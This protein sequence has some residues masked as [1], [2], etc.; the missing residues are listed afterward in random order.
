M[1][2]TRIIHLYRRFRPEF[3]GDG[4]Y[5]EHLI[6]LMAELGTTHI[7]LAFDTPK[8][9]SIPN[10]NF[11]IHYLTS[12]AGE[13][14]RFA[15]IS[16]LW[17][18]RN[19]FDVLHIHSHV[20]RTFLSYW[21]ARAVGL[22]VIYSSTL[23]DSADELL[24]GYRPSFRPLVRL[25]F[26]GIEFF[27]GNSPRLYSGKSRW[28][29]SRRA[30]VI[31]QGT[32]YPTLISTEDRDELRR[33]FGVESGDIVL[34]YVGSICARKGI[35]SLVSTF[36]LSAANNSHVRLIMVGPVIE[37]EYG[38]N[39]FRNIDEMSLTDRVMH[40]SFAENVR[41]YYQISDAFVFS[42]YN[43]GFPNV[44]LEAMS[45]GLP[46][47]SRLI[48]EVTDTFIEDGYS[49]YL[50][51]SDDFHVI[52]DAVIADLAHGKVMGEHARQRVHDSFLITDIAQRYVSLYKST[53]RRHSLPDTPPQKV[54]ELR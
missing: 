53:V 17:A 32:T 30:T 41:P 22:R 49:G 19:N 25:L 16:W 23:E 39:V 24:A 38:A 54:S 7:V 6:P 29:G 27:V 31:P 34:L 3:T 18:N 1:S 14:S 9:D 50:F 10:F 43:E 8:P 36:A 12:S 13:R 5:Y 15:L 47:V 45:F 33:S 28:I 42:S 4:I 2:Q 40:V 51:L 37:P 35:L 44:L 26:Y 46:I 52:L 20:D 11:Q 21:F 48:P